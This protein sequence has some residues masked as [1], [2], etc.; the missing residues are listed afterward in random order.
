ML[1]NLEILKN[2][3]LEHGNNI[4]FFNIIFNFII[5]NNNA[6]FTKWEKLALSKIK[7]L[8]N[9]IKIYILKD[10]ALEPGNKYSNKVR[11]TQGFKTIISINYIIGKFTQA[12]LYSPHTWGN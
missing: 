9:S 8:S 4:K 12:Y 2:V 7:I 3:A 5:W 11:T 10:F 1:K 6:Y